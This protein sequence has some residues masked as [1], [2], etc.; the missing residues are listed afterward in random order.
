[1]DDPLSRESAHLKQAWS[2]HAPADLRDYLVEDVEDP[3]LN[4]QSILTRHLITRALVGDQL[5]AL[6]DHELR[7]AC[8][9]NWLLAHLRRGVTWAWL[10]AQLDALVDAQMDAASAEPATNASTAPDD[11]PGPPT[12][13]R[14]TAKRLPAEGHDWRVP[15]YL[16]SALSI[17]DEELSQGAVPERVLD[18]FAPIWAELMQRLTPPR[19]LRVL[20]PACGSANDYRFLEA[21]GLSQHLDYH[22]FD[23]IPANVRNARALC[24]DAAE[25]FTVGNAFDIDAADDTF[26]VLFVHDLLEHLSPAGIE[27][28]VAEMSRVTRGVA[29]IHFFNLADQPEDAIYPFGHYYW[30]LL[31]L[32]R[33]RQRL[34]AH[35][36]AVQAIHIPAFL[37]EHYQFHDSHNRE[38]WTLVVRFHQPSDGA[39]G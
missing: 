33:M 3:R 13:L 27:R 4:A 22:G 24:P 9:M 31:S 12:H 15:N 7:F 28:A 18:T 10:E 35:G 25:R 11:P 21:F 37:S 26:D 8:A 39:A 17:S 29:M 30:N 32:S 5:D 23:I 6:C 16:M 20:E 14:E 2:G 38:A 1:M 19:P 36:G 34:E